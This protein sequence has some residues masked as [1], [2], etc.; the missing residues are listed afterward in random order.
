[1]AL[2]EKWKFTAVLFI[3]VCCLLGYSVDVLIGE[4][5]MMFM[6]DIDGFE[7]HWTMGLV[8]QKHPGFYGQIVYSY[9][10]DP[11]QSYNKK[12]AN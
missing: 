7:A 1:M 8:T 4:I 11:V 5:K 6:K 10:W 9:V 2:L 3:A 12:G